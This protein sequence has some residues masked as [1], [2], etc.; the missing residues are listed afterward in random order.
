[1]DSDCATL[2]GV[3]GILIIQMLTFH[4]A[5]IWD[6]I[7]MSRNP[8]RRRDV[9]AVARGVMPGMVKPAA[10][11]AS[12]GDVGQ[13]QLDGTPVY[14]AELA[15]PAAQYNSYMPVPQQHY[16]QQN[17]GPPQELSGTS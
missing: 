13:Y 11:V 10:A 16:Q 4:G 3:F 17:P 7:V 8:N 12:G 15:T 9:R 5:I 2:K 14:P 6:V 1:M